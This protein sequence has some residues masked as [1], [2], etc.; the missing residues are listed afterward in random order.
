[1]NSI[2]KFIKNNKIL[3]LSLLGYIILFTY[4]KSLGIKAVKDSTYYFIEMIEILPAVFVLTSLIQTWIPTELIIKN[5][6]NGSGLKGT[7][8]S[9][10]IGSLSAGPI[11]AA[12][13]VCRM[14]LNKGASIKNIIIILSSWAVIKVPM[15]INEIKFMGTK[16]MI[17]RWIFTIAAIIGMAYLMDKLLKKEDV[18]AVEL[19]ETSDIPSISPICVG[20]GVCT[21]I[22]PAVFQIKDRKAIV[23]QECNFNEWKKEIEEAKNTCPVNA[24]I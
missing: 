18:I 9:F 3:V 21:K 1:M 10:T 5:F 2:K 15:L 20:C 19:K 7:I 11:Y 22:C 16:Y 14:L 23:N 8:I 24:I 4:N 12:F 17:V 6:G 13:P